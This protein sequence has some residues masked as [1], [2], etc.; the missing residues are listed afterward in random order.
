MRKIEKKIS[1]DQELIFLQNM[2]YKFYQ[3]FK[4]S[5]FTNV[6]LYFLVQM[7]NNGEQLFQPPF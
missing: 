3:F 1:L 5:D 2:S 4:E 7:W 6:V